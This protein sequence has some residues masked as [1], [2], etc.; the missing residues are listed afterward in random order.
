MNVHI[1][2]DSEEEPS[3]VAKIQRCFA[4]SKNCSPPEEQIPCDVCG[5]LVPFKCFEEHAATHLLHNRVAPLKRP[6]IGNVTSS[7]SDAVALLPCEVCGQLLSFHDYAAHCVDHETGQLAEADLSSFDTP[8]AVSAQLVE[9]FRASSEAPLAGGMPALRYGS[10]AN[11]DLAVNFIRQARRMHMSHGIERAKIYVV[12]HWTPRKNF[13]P[14]IDGNLRVPDG[15][16]V[17][18]QTDTG[19]YG[20]G[21]YTS[22]DFNYG[23]AYAH[24]DGACIICMSLPGRQCPSTYPRDNGAPCRPGYDSHMST[25]RAN[26]E[27]VFFASDQL[28]PCFIVD[29]ASYQI[30]LAAVNSTIQ[31]WRSRILGTGCADETSPAETLPKSSRRELAAAAAERRLCKK[32]KV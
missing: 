7:G 11:F 14:I 27:W 22:P 13:R 9:H 5:A 16:T 24:G 4:A 26:M 19:F 3:A 21:I 6:S 32:R 31:T 10:I 25:D 15:R 30:A 18:H 28:L 1:T 2:S 17:F 20:A 12:Y 29:D 8:E 23:K